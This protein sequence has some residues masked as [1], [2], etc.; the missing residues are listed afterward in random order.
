MAVTS[1]QQILR[2]HSVDIPNLSI[3]P[4]QTSDTPI[5]WPV[6]SASS[7]DDDNMDASLLMDSAYIQPLVPS[8][9]SDLVRTIFNPDNAARLRHLSARKF[10]AW[11]RTHTQS[12]SPQNT[13]A[14]HQTT[15]APASSIL[16]SPSASQVLVSRPNV[17]T[18]SPAYALTRW[19]TDLQQSLRNER[20]RYQ[21]VP[22][23]DRRGWLIERWRNSD[24]PAHSGGRKH[25][26][27]KAHD[28]EKA[29]LV[30]GSKNDASPLNHCAGPLQDPLGLLACNDMIRRNG[31]IIARIL[32]GCG[33]LGAIALWAMKTWGWGSND[34][35]GHWGGGWSL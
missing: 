12:S 8:G 16:S 19:A 33:I 6:S 10:L 21:R 14:E 11:R 35:A 20:D 24:S 4:S 1:I 30:T 15:N 3:D 22:S 29:D 2:S 25:N 5:V 32:G 9:L 23:E 13:A 18:G 7:T 31:T 34:E 28:L 17:S 27:E 26:T